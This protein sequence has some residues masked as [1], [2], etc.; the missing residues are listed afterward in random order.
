MSLLP[1]I[2]T[3]NYNE[4][5]G[6]NT[7]IRNTSLK[8]SKSQLSLKTSKNFYGK[9]NL[10][11][12]HNFNNKNN[13]NKNNKNNNIFIKNQK[14]T[15]DNTSGLKIINKNIIGKN[16]SN[17]NRY[18]KKE[19]KNFNKINDLKNNL[20]FYSSNVNDYIEEANKIIYQRID[21]KNAELAGLKCVDKKIII[22]DTRE[23]SRNNVVINTIKRDI[24]RM[25]LAEKN[26]N[27]CLVKSQNDMKKDF[28]NFNAFIREKDDKIK[29]ENAILL[30]L[31]D[32][33]EKKLEMYDKEYQIYKKFSEELEK[34]VKIIC[35]LKDYGNFI[36]KILGKKFWLDG[37]PE[38]N[39][40]TKN[41]EH[42]SDLVIEKFNSNDE[43]KIKEEEDYFDDGFLIIKFNDLERKIIQSI[44]NTEFNIWDLKE[45]QYKEQSLKRMT[46]TISDLNFQNNLVNKNQRRLVKN[47]EKAKSIKFDEESTN[48][49]LD[50][51]IELEKETEKNNIDPIFYF[52]E[53]AQTE[54]EKTTIKTYD[55]KYHAVKT[56][57]NL[58]KKETLINKFI[59]FID[60]LKRSENKD[61]ILEIENDMKNK[62][63]KEKLRRLKLKQEQIHDEKNRKTLERNSRYVIIGRTV[64]K[65]FQF[66]KNKHA[67]TSLE[68]KVKDNI[69]LLYY[70]ED[71]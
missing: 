65:I 30:K 25:K 28:K 67:S 44:K 53:L 56:L 7:K 46:N 41:F 55:P 10:I 24:R 48:K 64:P 31:S 13:K 2:E 69:E 60:K 8:N 35:L 45:K 66:N 49:Y 26:Y 23:I 38:I 39:Q 59:E 63:K 11:K 5:S 62:N 22:S 37:I 47:V 1:K 3:T 40:K 9:L 61:I 57:N 71:D 12:K 4:K 50:Y 17:N 20:D 34:R 54:H 32:D 15:I 36:Y 33:H 27:K 70:N 51:I 18:L 19:K 52:P 16:L 14:L 58:R 21:D 68:N 6:N 43:K 29:A 42:I